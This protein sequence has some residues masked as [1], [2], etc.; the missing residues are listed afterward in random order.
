MLLEEKFNIKQFILEIVGVIFGAAIMAVGVSLF[1]LPNQLSSGGFSGIAT[2]AYYLLKIPM[3]TTII[4][5]NV[6]LFI[7]AFLKLGKSFFIKSI[8]GTISLSVFID[9]FDKII[10]LTEDRFLACIYGGI[11]VG[12]GTALILKANSSTGGSE[13]ISNIV[14]KYNSNAKMGRIITII[15][16]IVVIINVIAFRKIEIGL[17]SA[18][19]IYI[20]GKVIDIIVEGIYFTKLVFIIS[21]KNEEISKE[22]GTNIRRGTTGLYGKGM[23]KKEDKLVLV[24]AVSRNDISKIKKLVKEVDKK[25]FMIITNSREVLGLGFKD[26]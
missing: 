12:I 8:V 11:I 5:L 22:I 26:V 13:L 14:K 6:P 10:P 3:G 16:I 20:M 7:F 2:L 21:D 9:M 24:C 19:D 17:Y 1:L 18:I 15:D 23:Y 4:I 25:A